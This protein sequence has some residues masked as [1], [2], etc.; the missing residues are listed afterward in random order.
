MQHVNEVMRKSIERSGGTFISTWDL[1][2]QN[3]KYSNAV[4]VD[5]ALHL[6]RDSDGVHFTRAGAVY[7]ARKVTERLEREVP[8]LPADE[9][10]ALIVRREIDSKALGRRVP[11]LAYVPLV[12][13]SGGGDLPALFLLHGVDGSYADWS[14]HAQAALKEL[15]V[16][17][18]LVIITPEGG[19]GGWYVDSAL[20]P[21]S[22]YASHVTREVVAD[23]EA[24][25]PVTKR[26]GIAGVSA[27]GHGALTLALRSPGLFSS[28]SSMSGVVDLPAAHTR[29]ALVKRL[30]PYSENREGWEE[31]SARHLARSRADVARDLPMLITVGRADRWAP[32]N[33]A[34]AAELAELGVRHAFEEYEGGHDWRTFKRQLPRH[35]AWHAE[36]LAGPPVSSAPPPR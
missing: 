14:E 19:E 15:S 20:V 3:G 18:G 23:I 36:Q 13:A 7:M 12:A 34:F 26:R 31:R 27:G 1:S 5:G 22:N 35:V 6:L 33:R 21:N 32:E 25:L 17:H 10:R 2:G 11:Y 28:A 9:G 24:N 16:R 4:R 8:L 30:G 29:K